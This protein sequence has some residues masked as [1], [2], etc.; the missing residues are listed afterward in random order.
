MK[1]T[2]NLFEPSS[3]ALLWIGAADDVE[4]DLARSWARQMT[5][6]VEA[7]DIASA[8]A[9]SW[10]GFVDRSPAAV[11]LA[12]PTPF[13]WSVH[14][15]IAVAR[16]WPLAPLVSVC[17]SL[18]D[19]R[20]RSGPQLPGVEEVAWSDLPGRLSWWL[21]DRGRGRPGGLGMPATARREERL[22]E[23]AGRVT[24][25]GSRGGG[26]VAVAAARQI[27]LEGLADLLTAA[28]RPPVRR[29]CG[30]PAVDE[31]ADIVVWDVASASADDLTWLRMLAA[32]RPG[33]AVIL[34]ES[35]PRGDWCA[36]ALASGAA[37]VLARPASLESLTGLLLRLDAAHAA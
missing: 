31:P 29:V 33:L 36:A 25:F 37:A 10:P 22:L 30:R 16:R 2:V 35:F 5:Y 32:N 28:G 27:D 7:A 1:S 24:E 19:G 9:G 4:L 21:H 26:R 11:L 23:A 18:V 6:L 17:T 34:L 15:C 20:R 8:C 13:A 14:D 3:P 12:S